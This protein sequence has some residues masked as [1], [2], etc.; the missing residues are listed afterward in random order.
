MMHKMENILSD[1]NI[2]YI[3]SSDSAYLNEHIN[4][5]VKNFTTKHE[6][7]I[8]PIPSLSIGC[9]VRYKLTD[10]VEVG[11]LTGVDFSHN[12]KPTIY[13]V[14]FDNGRKVQTTRNHI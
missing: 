2:D 12:S 6:D 7:T 14:T 10:H 9:S 3:N 5:E 13:E 11:K 1:Q 4:D 8:P